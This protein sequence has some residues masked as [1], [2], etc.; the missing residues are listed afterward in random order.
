[1]RNRSFALDGDYVGKRIRIAHRS[2]SGQSIVD[3]L[4]VGCLYWIAM[5]AALIAGALWRAYAPGARA[6]GLSA[7]VFVLMIVA[8]YIFL[9][10]PVG[11]ACGI[12]SVRMPR[13]PT[14]WLVLC[15]AASGSMVA[16]ICSFGRM[17]PEWDVL[18]LYGGIVAAL[19]MQVFMLTR[20]EWQ[21]EHA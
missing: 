21:R 12:A 2:T 14:M 13:A 6:P 1:M 7:M 10:F 19:S 11:V 8:F 20:R 15:M 5:I 4:R 9:A 18:A 16:A 3:R 17:R